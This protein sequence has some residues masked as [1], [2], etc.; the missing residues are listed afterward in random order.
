MFPVPDASLDAVEICADI[1]CRENDL[2]VGHTVI[3]DKYD[4]QL[5]VDAA[6][7]VHHLRNGVDQLDRLLC[8]QVTCSRLSAEDKCPRVEGNLRVLLDLVVQIH[9]MKDVQELSLILVETF[10]LYVKDGSRIH[11]NA[12][13]LPDIF[14]QTHFVLVLDLHELAPCVLI[15]YI[16]L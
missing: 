8:S 15:V 7:I 5:A 1:C 12:V 13:V 9:D 11:F 2:R 3:L 14:C 10:Y 6:V 4:F 16:W